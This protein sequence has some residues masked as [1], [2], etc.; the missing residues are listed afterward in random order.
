MFLFF[1][2]ETTGLPNSRLPIDHKDQPHIVQLAALLC[3]AEQR[4]LASFS[5]IVNPGV[6]IPKQASDVHGITD[7]MARTY[8]ISPKLAVDL[9]KQLYQRANMLV[10]HNI[11]F[12]VALISTAIARTMGGVRKLEKPQYCTMETATPIVNLPPTERMIAAGFNKP[13]PPRL[14][15]CMKYFFDEDLEGAHDAMIDV[16]ACQVLFFHLRSLETK[17]VEA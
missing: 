13:K 7:E 15:E 9:F 8:G 4:T 1:D 17:K 6:P 11:K 14:E 10:A 16:A 3:D 2:T 12:D 5:L